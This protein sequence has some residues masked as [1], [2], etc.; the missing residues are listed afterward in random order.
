MA[1]RAPSSPKPRTGRPSGYTETIADEITDRIAMG[2][3][4]AKICADAHMPSPSMVF[5]WLD[6]PEYVPFRDRYA[7]AREIQ[8]ETLAD[9]IIQIAN[10]PEMGETVTDKGNGTIETRTGD[11]IE[12]RRLKVDA[13]KWFASKVAPARY[14]D[15][16]HSTVTGPDG[17]A[18]QIE[19]NDRER[20]KAL[21]LLVAKQREG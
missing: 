12:H 18:I 14:G 8:A 13:R 17:G 10:T 1:K 9:E 21:A 4:L 7:R 5:R 15:K 2:Q 6:N 3:S 11:M 19:T 16:T 20:A